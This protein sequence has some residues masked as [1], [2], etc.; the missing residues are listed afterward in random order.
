MPFIIKELKEQKKILHEYA[1]SVIRERME[2]TKKDIEDVLSSALEDEKRSAGDKYETGREMAQQ[3]L[4]KL[5]KTY[6]NLKQ[7]ELILSRMEPDRKSEVVENGSVVIT[8]KNALYVSVGLGRVE[9]DGRPYL[10]ISRNAPLMEAF[11]GKKTGDKVT[12]NDNTY[13]IKEIL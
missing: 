13:T 11:S 6:D 2:Q 7:M 9:L 8:D 10:L 12:F 5:R 3:E 1:L 4:E